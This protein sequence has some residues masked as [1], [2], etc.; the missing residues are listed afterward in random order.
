M[1]MEMPKLPTSAFADE[2]RDASWASE[3]L[4]L[5]EV[6]TSVISDEK[7][8]ALSGSENEPSGLPRGDSKE[9]VSEGREPESAGTCQG[10]RFGIRASTH[11]RYIL[12][13]VTEMPV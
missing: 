7:E 5:D 8:H 1:L 6:V 2:L 9:R 11:V 10:L 3:S 12:S 13:R 4:W